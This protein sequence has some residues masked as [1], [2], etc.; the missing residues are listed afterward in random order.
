M[1]LDGFRQ[2]LPKLM[3]EDN[4]ARTKAEVSLTVH[5]LIN[6]GSLALLC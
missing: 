6:S 2:L 1:N 4:D 3:S 5:M